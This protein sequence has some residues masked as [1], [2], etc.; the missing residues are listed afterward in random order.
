MTMALPVI[1]PKNDLLTGA[2]WGAD[3][4]RELFRLAADI[5]AHPENYRASL[6]GKFLA[7]IFEKP[8]LRTRV[9]FDVG[10]QSL[11][12]STVF[13][14]YEQQHLGVRESIR[15]MARNLQR[16]VQGIVARVFE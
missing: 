4:V 3:T 15:D 11:G 13:L 6:T 16:W 10:M 1:L 2:E 8:S 14:D 9:S 7:M 5:K 12:G